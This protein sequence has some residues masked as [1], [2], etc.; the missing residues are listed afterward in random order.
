MRV[1]RRLIAMVCGVL[2]SA[3]SLFAQQS[4]ETSPL[5][6]VKDKSTM[7]EWGIGAIFLVGALVVAFKPA[8]RSNLR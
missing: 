1:R 8:K 6:K 4:Y 7:V 2:C 3:A 5:E